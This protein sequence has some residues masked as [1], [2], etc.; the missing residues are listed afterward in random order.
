M[1]TKIKMKLTKKIKFPKIKVVTNKNYKRL[2]YDKY[3][4]NKKH[5]VFAILNEDGS[6]SLYDKH[7]KYE[8]EMK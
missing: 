2:G 8:G 1:I 3:Y 7:G 4:S 5:P 6:E